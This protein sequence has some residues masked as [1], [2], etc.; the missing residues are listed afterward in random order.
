MPKQVVKEYFAPELTT[1]NECDFAKQV[2]KDLCDNPTW[3]VDKLI[4]LE[5]IR[6]AIVVFN[7][8]PLTS[9]WKPL[10]PISPLIGNGEFPTAINTEPN[11]CKNCYFYEQYL[12][13]GKIYIGD[14][15]CEWCQHSKFKITCLAK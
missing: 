6:M 4:Y 8:E 13:D 2:N 1:D 3:S 15:P 12:K 11:P 10:T 9:N 5:D 14:S 7:V